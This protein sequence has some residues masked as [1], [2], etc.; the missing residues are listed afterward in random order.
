MNVED[1]LPRLLEE[2]CSGS[3]QTNLENKQALAKQF[4]E[5]MKFCLSFDDI[6]VQ[7]F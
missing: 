5:V 7:Y 1:V 2:L 6:K 4:A 3:P